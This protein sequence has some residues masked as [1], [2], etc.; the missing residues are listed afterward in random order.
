MHKYIESE[1]E[2]FSEYFTA[3]DD[4]VSIITNLVTRHY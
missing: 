3:E 4:K 1:V 2:E